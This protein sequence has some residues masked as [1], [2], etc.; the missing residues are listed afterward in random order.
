MSPLLLI[1]L[2]SLIL[3][4]GALVWMTGLIIGRVLRERAEASRDR[5][6]QVIQHAFLD[7]MAGSGDAIGRLRKVQHR[8]RTLAAR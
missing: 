5:D 1:W 3:A 7:I 4:G 2:T 8:M 6:R